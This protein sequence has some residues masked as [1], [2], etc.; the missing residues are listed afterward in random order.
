MSQFGEYDF[1]LVEDELLYN[2]N[3]NEEKFKGY[4]FIIFASKHS[5]KVSTKTL[6][7]HAPG[8]FSEAKLGGEPGK[9]CTSSALFQKHLF[10]KLQEVKSEHNL[11]DYALTMEGTHHSP[12]INI[13]CLF[14]EIGSTENEWKDRK[15]GFVIAKALNQAIKTFT[16]SPYHDIAVGIGGPHYCP[17]FN[18]IQLRS[19]VAISHVISQY[20]FPLT[21][22]SLLESINKTHEEVDFVVLDWKG[23][24][25]SEEKKKLIQTLEDNYIS[26][27]KSGEIEKH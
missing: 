10:L 26:W 7:I 17:N 22:E 8:N 24:G 1:Y 12:L 21:K 9:V 4:D 6:S 14:L 11:H 27:K 19:N 18:K 2:K 15:A 20:N 5:S 25:K 3:I 13:P 23:L 16:V